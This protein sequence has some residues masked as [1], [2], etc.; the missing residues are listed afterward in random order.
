MR[1]EVILQAA[2]NKKELFNRI[3]PIASLQLLYDRAGR[4]RGIAF[5][6][7][8]D[9]RDADD[10]VREFN[11][12]NAYGQPIHLT[13]MPSGPS[14]TRNGRPA[15]PVRNDRGLADRAS[16]GRSLFER[17]QAPRHARSSSPD[18]RKPRGPPAGI[19]RYVPGEGSAPSS[20]TRSPPQRRGGEGGRRPGEKREGGGRG[21]RRGPAKDDAG[22]MLVQGRPRKT[23][24]ELDEEMT[25]YF[26]DI[27]A[28]NDGNDGADAEVYTQ[29]QEMEQPH[30][31][32]P[33]GGAAPVDEDVDMIE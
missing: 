20:R 25:D 22:R 14:G 18:R 7:Y 8:E 32:A 21:G 4:S 6:T 28:S 23:A 15:R 16:G 12:A 1:H 5:V 24:E 3:A 33:G 10:A 9:A 13:V 26:R 31:A 29:A 17:V 30:A 2:D 19:D 11:G 27:G